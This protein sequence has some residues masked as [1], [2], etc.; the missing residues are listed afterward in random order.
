VWEAA[1]RHREARSRGLW[2]GNG[3]GKNLYERGTTVEKKKKGE[4]GKE[5]YGGYRQVSKYVWLVKKQ[6]VRKLP[7]LRE[8]RTQ[9]SNNV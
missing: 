5:I 3:T 9:T 2:T 7:I 6:V 8:S 1:R 4:G